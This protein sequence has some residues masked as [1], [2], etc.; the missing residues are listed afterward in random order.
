MSGSRTTD[1]LSQFIIGAL[2][3]GQLNA[4]INAAWIACYL[5][6]NP[7]WMTKVREEVATVANRYNPKSTAPLVDQLSNIPVEAWETE[8]ET[9]DLCLR[10]SIR[11]Q[12][13]GSAFRRNLSGKDIALGD[14]V[15]PN[16]ACVV[17]LWNNCKPSAE[18]FALLD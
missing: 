7:E 18:G 1:W 8:F 12:L 16:G 2:F 17:S 9:I 13:L 3:A 10:D 5:A 4:S 11:L 14:Q 6:L 15:I